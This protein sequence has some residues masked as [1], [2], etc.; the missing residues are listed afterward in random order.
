V[1]D[2]VGRARTDTAGET[3][4]LAV[5]SFIDKIYYELRN[6]GQSAPDRA[7]NYAGTNVF[8][9]AQSIVDATLAA[10]DVPGP[11]NNLYVMD[12]IE[13]VKSPYCRMDSDC[14]DVKVTFFDPEEVRRAKKVLLYTIDVS[15]VMPV[16]LAP[17][18]TFL[19]T[20]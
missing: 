12:T 4:R 17:V 3:I 14:W 2:E 16:S 9:L 19:S 10:R 20:F 7:L 13:V 11:S 1:I 18:H 5:R 8:Q 15:D 6:L